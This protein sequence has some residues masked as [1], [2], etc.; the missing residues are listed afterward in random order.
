MINW[1]PMPSLVYVGTY[2]GPKSKSI[3]L[4]RLQTENREVPQNITLVPL[5]VSA[6]TPSPS[7]LT[8]DVGRHLLFTVN[9][10]DN[11]EGKASG[12]VSAFQIDTATGKLTALNQRPSMGTGPCHLALDRWRKNLLVANYNSGSVAV[13]PISDDGH[14]GE[15]SD[16]VQ[17]S[18]SS[19]N[20]DRQKGPHA[21]CITFDPAYRFVFVCDLGLDKILT[22]RLDAGKGKLAAADPPFTSTKPGA[23]PRHMAF[24]PDGRFAYVINEL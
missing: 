12:A 6:E 13:F 16:V 14:L 18:G 17:H 9:E 11:F 19:V 1:Q 5:G 20:P 24:R 10:I 23:G 2:T 21:H 4:F 7:F 15:A 8:V 22:Y 3:Y